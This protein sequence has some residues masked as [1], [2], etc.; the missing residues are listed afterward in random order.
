MKIKRCP[1]KKIKTKSGI[2]YIMKCFWCRKPV[3]VANY[4]TKVVCCDCTFDNKVMPTDREWKEY[5][6]KL[7]KKIKERR[8]TDAS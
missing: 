5:R 2:E 1:R 3:K 7:K 6:R 4:T 8:E